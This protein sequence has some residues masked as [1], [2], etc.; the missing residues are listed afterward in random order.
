MRKFNWCTKA[1]RR[2][3]EGVGRM[4]YL[5]KVRKAFKNGYKPK[6]TVKVIGE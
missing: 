1:L 4:R 6:E 5:K 2:R 3:T